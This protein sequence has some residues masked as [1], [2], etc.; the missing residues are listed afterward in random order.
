MENPA[1]TASAADKINIVDYGATE[2]YRVRW[3][4]HCRLSRSGCATG[5]VP[6]SIS[7]FHFALWGVENWITKGNQCEFCEG[8]FFVQK[9]MVM[10]NAINLGRRR[11]HASL[12]SCRKI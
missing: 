12:P 5:F 11:L 8:L 10:E 2:R 9:A 7:L 3:R 1:K 4:S 6:A